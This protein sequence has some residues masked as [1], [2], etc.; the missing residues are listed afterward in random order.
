MVCEVTR[1]EDRDWRTINDFGI[2]S[3]GDP[4]E[5]HAMS[6]ESILVYSLLDL[7]M[8]CISSMYGGGRLK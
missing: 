3:S 4:L 2:Y 5:S 1:R 6:D 7:R 8:T